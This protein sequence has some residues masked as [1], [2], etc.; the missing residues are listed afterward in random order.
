MRAR[1]R[2]LTALGGLVATSALL[3]TTGLAAAARSTVVG[4][5]TGLGIHSALTASYRFA[6]RVGMSEQMYTPAQ[7][8]KMHP[9]GGEVMLR[10]TMS[11]MA[12]MSMSGSMRHVEVQ[13][14]NRST[15]A[16]LTNANPTVFVIDDS[17]GGMTMKMPVAV[18]EGVGAGP[19]DLHYGNNVTMAAG[20]NYRI[21]VSL[22]GQTVIFHLRLPK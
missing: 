8:K 11:G 20:H 13:I 21:R 17:S 14:C 4:C 18:M 15:G 22:K 2:I 1:T 16:V 3:P 5:K 9:K 7:V 12:G 10:G 19:S 6:L